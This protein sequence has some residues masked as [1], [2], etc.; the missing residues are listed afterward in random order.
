MTVGAP[1]LVGAGLLLVGASRCFGD[2]LA[3]FVFLIL[4]SFVLLAQ[5]DQIFGWLDV[6]CQVDG[7]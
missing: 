3:A 2:S 5:N 4:E 6:N 7:C 1:T